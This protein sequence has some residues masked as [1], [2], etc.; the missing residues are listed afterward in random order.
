MPTRHSLGSRSA[1]QEKIRLR[2][3]ESK[4]RMAQGLPSW[5]ASG[6]NASL[7]S[8]SQTWSLFWGALAR[9]KPTLTKQ[10]G[11]DSVPEFLDFNTL[12]E[13]HFNGKQHFGYFFGQSSQEVG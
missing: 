9:D 5:N 11:F 6:T 12:W 4:R 8:H 13:G 2:K 3:A 7:P 1:F 10:T